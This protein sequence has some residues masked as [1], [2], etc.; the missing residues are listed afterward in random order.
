MQGFTRA[1]LDRL[2][3]QRDRHGHPSGHPGCRYEH[4]CDRLSRNAIALAAP[5]IP[6]SAFAKRS[7][8]EMMSGMAD[9]VTAFFVINFGSSLFLGR[10]SVSRL[11]S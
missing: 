7:A 8:S 4:R 5:H 9:T 1:H 2:G 6:S 3:E 10:L 11:D